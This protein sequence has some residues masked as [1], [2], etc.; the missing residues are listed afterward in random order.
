M[1]IS[2]SEIH[3]GGT[4]NDGIIKINPLI[5]SFTQTGTGLSFPIQLANHGFCTS[6]TRIELLK[7]SITEILSE[8]QGNGFMNS[9]FG[10]KLH[11]LKYEN[12]L[13]VIKS[14]GKT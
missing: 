8:L 13:E 9:S 12:N 2:G 5:P 6:E 11:L 14:S 10:G 7:Q 1:V 3:L 4:A